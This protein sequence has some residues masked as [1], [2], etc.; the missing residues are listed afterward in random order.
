M[1]SMVNA[2]AEVLAVIPARGGSQSIPRKNICQMGGHTLL[3]WS[4]AAAH[5]ATLVNRCVVSTDDEEIAAI[6]QSYGAEVPFIRPSELARNDTRDFPVF[7]HAIRWLER[8]EGYQPD[9]VVQLRPT[10][11]LRPPGLVDE[12]VELLLSTDEAD[13]VRSVTSPSQ[14]PYKMWTLSD[15]LLKPLLESD[16]KEPYNTPRQ[17]LPATYWQTGH[18]DVFRTRTIRQ[19]FSLTGD[20]ILPVIVDSSYAIDIDTLIHLRLA[21]ELVRQDELDLVKPSARKSASPLQHALQEEYARSTN[22]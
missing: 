21:E 1:D 15:G 9:I 13:S 6:A 4:I 3:A 10:S 14:N 19:K 8:N 7:R 16:L 2:T 17:L 20:R 22:R 5:Q 18:I 11:P 12:A